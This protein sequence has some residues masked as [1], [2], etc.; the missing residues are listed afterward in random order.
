MLII[1]RL[2]SRRWILA[3]LLVVVGVAVL[4][5]LGIWQLDRLAQRRVFNT[6]V[7]SQIDLPPLLLEKDAPNLDLTNMEYR[8]VEVNGVYDFSQ[9]VALR[10]QVWDNQLGVSLI[11]PLKIENSD[12]SI[13]VER[14]WIPVEDFNHGNLAPYD[15]EGKVNVKGVIRRSQNLPDFGSMT[16]P[17]L[18]PGETHLNLW[19]FAD[20][21]R[22]AEQLPYPILP[23]YIQE[24]PDP[25][26]TDMPYRTAPQLDLSE[27]PHMSYAIQ[28]FSFATML[29]IGYPIF[30]LRKEKTKKTALHGKR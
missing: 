27:G 17:T 28:W 23:V 5:R 26:W 16:D 6:R 13:L 7:T 9:Q 1:L 22:I 12:K 21:E 20:V 24:S 3:T 4:I 25:S 19:N 30:M 29:G 11:T 15:Q 18:A 2:F 8:S 14:G 10:N